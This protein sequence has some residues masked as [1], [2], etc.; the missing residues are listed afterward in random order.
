MKIRLIIFYV[1]LFAAL[2]AAGF[3]ISSYFSGAMTIRR[4]LTENKHLKEAITNLTAEDQIGYAKVISTS[5]I[6]GKLFTTIRFVETARNDKSKKILRKDYIIE[7]DIVHFDALIV[8]F[9]DKM[10]MD[11]RQK[12]LYLCRRIYGEKTPPDAGLAI[13]QPGAEPLRYKDILR[14][15]PS[16]Q[17]DMFWAN[18]WD[19]AHNPDKL[20]D[21]DIRAVYG[22]VLY[23]QLRTGFI[24]VFRVTAAGQL[25]PEIVPEM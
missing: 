17:K 3:L 24:Y 6:D 9:G 5:T 21:Y 25:Y 7:G 12:S 15:L 10:V 2:I 11:G 14:F 16:G 23:T 4:L 22:S 1:F 8:K 20:A 18:I 19:L 13:E